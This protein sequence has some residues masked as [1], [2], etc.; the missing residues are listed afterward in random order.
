MIVSHVCAAVLAESTIVKDPDSPAGSAGGSGRPSPDT[1]APLRCSRACARSW[2]DPSAS[3]P[4]PRRCRTPR[5]VCSW[6]LL[7]RL[8]HGR[9]LDSA[10][11]VGS[12]S[13]EVAAPIPM[14]RTNNPRM[15]AV[16]IA[17]P[18]RPRCHRY[19]ARRASSQK[20][21]VNTARTMWSVLC[22]PQKL[23]L[24]SEVATRSSSCPPAG[25][26]SGF[27]AKR[28]VFPA[29]FRDTSG[30]HVA[31]P[32][33]TKAPISGAFLERMMGLEPTTFCMASR[34]STN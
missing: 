28:Q 29:N 23:T 34:R 27:P 2:S 17:Q 13:G 26:A 33:N 12:D 15:E 6:R 31:T 24:R 4:F 14:S 32:G 11:V 5:V 1:S 8:L 19:Q 18:R 7:G 10:A 30:T 3:R 22:L 21:R 16:A 25:N 20:P 9:R